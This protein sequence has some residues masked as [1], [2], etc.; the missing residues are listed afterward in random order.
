MKETIFKSLRQVDFSVGESS[1]LPG[2]KL[3]NLCN[4]GRLREGVQ[5]EISAGL[6]REFFKDTSGT[7]LNKNNSFFVILVNALRTAL[8]NSSVASRM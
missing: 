2:W 7:T 3:E 4:Q 5:L 1:R 8:G 6:R